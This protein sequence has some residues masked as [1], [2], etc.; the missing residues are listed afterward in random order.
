VT[1]S[2]PVLVPLAIAV[3]AGIL[4]WDL[5]RLLGEHSEAWDDTYYWTIGMP[6]MLGT[7]FM[8]GLGFPEDPWRWALAIVVAQAA[9]ATFLDFAGDGEISLLPGGL[10][11]F[12][13]VAV[14]CVLAAYVGQWLRAR[15]P[16]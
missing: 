8:L 9:W 2:G 3:V 6:L 4:A 7:A 13:L 14:P 15:I 10:V 5:V 12:S 11:T 16:E 1:R